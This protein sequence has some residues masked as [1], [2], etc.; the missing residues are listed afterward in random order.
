[1]VE[2]SQRL[3]RDIESQH[4]GGFEAMLDEGEAKLGEEGFG[5]DAGDMMMDSICSLTAMKPSSLSSET[6]NKLKEASVSGKIGVESAV[7]LNAFMGRIYRDA[8]T[9]YKFKSWAS[10]LMSSIMNKGKKPS[11]VG[12]HR[13]LPPPPP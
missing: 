11:Y 1:M 9:S 6:L 8:S 5:S 7:W 13:A 4:D 10:G 3:K 2:S 12:S